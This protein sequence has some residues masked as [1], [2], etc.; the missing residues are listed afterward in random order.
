[1]SV[2]DLHIG[3]VRVMGMC[4]IDSRAR[5]LPTHGLTNVI[6]CDPAPGIQSIALVAGPDERISIMK[7]V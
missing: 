1:L 7:A 4:E 6:A 2:F 3:L 5:D